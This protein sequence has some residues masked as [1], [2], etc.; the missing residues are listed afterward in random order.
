VVG[1]FVGPVPPVVGK[2]VGPGVPSV[3]ETDGDEDEF[4]D[5]STAAVVAPAAQT[6]MAT[7]TN[8]VLRENFSIGFATLGS[9]M[10][11]HCYVEMRTGHEWRVEGSVLLA[12]WFDW[13]A[14]LAHS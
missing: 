13:R 9:S 3:R 1:D 14:I 12:C 8:R 11:V 2:T 6:A 10:S 4:D 7:N 5:T